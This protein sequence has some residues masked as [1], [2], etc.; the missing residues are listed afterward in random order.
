MRL[1]MPAS[2]KYARHVID[3][4]F[5]GVPRKVYRREDLDT[6]PHA[7]KT[8]LTPEEARDDRL[9]EAGLPSETIQVCEFLAPWHLP[10]HDEDPHP[11]LSREMVNDVESLVAQMRINEGEADFLLSIDVPDE[12]ALDKEAVYEPSGGDFREFW[13]SPE[14]ANRYRHT[15]KVHDFRDGEDVRPDLVGK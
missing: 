9:D 7:G 10:R 1:Y 6:L 11:L 4:G 12:L 3:E 5:M 13:L 14:E 8:V 15:L 2:V